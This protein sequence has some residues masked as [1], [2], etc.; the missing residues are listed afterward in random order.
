MM[1]PPSTLTTIDR[2]AISAMPNLTSIKLPQSVVTIGDSTFYNDTALTKITIT[3]NVTTI[4]YV[5]F[6]GCSALTEIHFEG[7]PPATINASAFKNVTATA[8][9]CPVPAWTSDVMQNYGG[10]ITW[11]KDNKVGDNVTWAL[12]SSGTLTLSGSG[13]TWDFP[14]EYPGFYYFRDQV[15]DIQV[16]SSVT[17]LGTY[18]FYNMNKAKRVIL[19]TSVTNISKS[20]FSM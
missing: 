17:S 12:S 15:T 11:V 7:N 19:E 20:C 14:S 6:S 3:K 16:Y 4:G 2:A 8:Y 18:L 5:A 9:Y 13:A 1:T 10:T